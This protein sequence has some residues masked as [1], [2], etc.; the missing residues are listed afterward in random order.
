MHT[1]TIPNTPDFTYIRRIIEE[2]IG[3]ETARNI[4]ADH[5]DIAVCV[6]RVCDY[7]R[8]LELKV[9]R[10]NPATGD[11]THRLQPGS[12]A[13]EPSPGALRAA[14]NLN[15]S[16][17]LSAPLT[18]T[19]HVRQKAVAK[20]IDHE[21]AAPL[22]LD[23]LQQVQATV[24]HLRGVPGAWHR[25]PEAEREAIERLELLAT[26]AIITTVRPDEPQREG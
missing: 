3:A 22:L 5:T 19:T 15:Y 7:A 26:Q 2:H 16:Q 23:A 6:Q 9:A 17:L 21:T 14:Q 10:Q 1:Q 18:G 13:Q 4:G 24:R 25:L 12:L 8:E 20:I 11:Q